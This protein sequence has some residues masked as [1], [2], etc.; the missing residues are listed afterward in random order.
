MHTV[1][2]D[3][4][5]SLDC[6]DANYHACLNWDTGSAHNHAIL[7]MQLK[8]ALKEAIFIWSIKHKLI[9]IYEDKMSSQLNE[10]TL[11]SSN[12][13]HKQHSTFS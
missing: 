3:S 10:V 11:L 6:Y 12:M 1:Y 8:K 5:K 7:I 4:A 2:A 9:I 13:P